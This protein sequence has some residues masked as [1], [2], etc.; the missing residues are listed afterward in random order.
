MKK[1]GSHV[2]M[3]KSLKR[4]DAAKKVKV[5]TGRIGSSKDPFDRS[6]GWYGKKPRPAPSPLLDFE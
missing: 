4:G 2:N 3:P 1:A 5:T 6:Y